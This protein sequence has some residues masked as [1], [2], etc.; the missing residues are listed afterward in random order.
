M[1]AVDASVLLAIEDRD[2]PNHASSRSLLEGGEP[3]A[4][5]DLAAYE[6]VSVA[7]R[8]WGDPATTE[9]LRS[10]VFELSTDG[11][12]IRA[13]PTLLAEAEQVALEYGITAYDAAYV[14]AA[15]QLGAPLASCDVRDLVSRGLASL[16]GDL[17]TEDR[18]R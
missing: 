14:A 15:R 16:P 17:L 6:V 4:T 12:L 7:V 13:T 2:D 18:L 5:L 10:R 8:R 9:R 3:L 11:L 1:L